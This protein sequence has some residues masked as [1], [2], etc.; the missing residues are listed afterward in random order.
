M[1]SVV[2]DNCVLCKTCVDV[3]PVGAFHEGD[4]MMVVDPDTCIDCGM[5]ISE[6]PNNAIHPADESDEKWV[7]FNAEKSKE[8]PEAAK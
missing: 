4:T 2:N 7:Q 3:C 5:C 8:W 6:C 1:P